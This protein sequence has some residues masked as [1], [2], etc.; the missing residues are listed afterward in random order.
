MML[1]LRL[2]YK[3]DY[4]LPQGSDSKSKG[5]MLS[6]SVE[7]SIRTRASQE[8]DRMTAYKSNELS[9]IKL[10]SWTQLPAPMM[11]ERSA[12]LTQL[13]K[14]VDR[15]AVAIFICCLILTVRWHREVISLLWDQWRSMWTYSVKRTVFIHS[16][17]NFLHTWTHFQRFKC[18][19]KWRWW[20]YV[21]SF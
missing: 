10:K 9:R 19:I 3:F 5:D 16:R 13:S 6:P 15:L 14:P 2:L 8:T 4:L 12:H 21:T 20:K 1:Q 18:L 17:R 11:S 7:T